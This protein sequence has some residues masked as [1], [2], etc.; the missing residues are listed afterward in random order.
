MKNNPL[1]KFLVIP[2]AIL[3]IFVVVKLFS[4]GSAEQ[5]IRAPETVALSTDEA[6]KLGVDGD[7]PGDTL[8]TIVVESRQ[9]KDQVS[10][11]LKNND[12]LKQQNIELQKR[13][14]NIDLN[15]D[16]KLQNV[17]QTMKQEA[18]QQ[19]QTLLDTLQQQ[20]NTLSSKSGS[21]NESGSDLPIGF[22]VQPG[23]GQGFKGG[24]GADVVWIEP[25][26]ATPVDVN[27]KPIAA[28]SNQTASGFNFPT[29]FGESVDRGQNALR[30]GAQS[31]ANEISPQEAR[32]QVRKV[33]TLPQ[34]STLMGSV[35]MSALIG[36]VPIDGTVNDPYPF[37]VLIGPDN[38]TANGIDLPD[39][40]GAVAS[41]T[42][43]GDWTLSCVRGQIKSL[44]FVFNDG[45]VRTLP[46]PQEETNSSQNSNNQNNGN[47]TTI[48][49]GLGWISDAYGIPCISGDRKSN[50]SQYIGSQVLITAAGAGAASLIKSDG[51]SGSF[52]NPQSG[53][54]GSVGGS[55][56]EAMGKIIGQG[57]N[58]VS[59]WV[60]KLYGQ[61]FA[62]V[63]VQ[64]GAKIAVHL[65]Q[66]LT[67]D[68]EL[69]GRKVNYRS[70]ARHVSTALD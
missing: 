49:G 32:K 23:D 61:A 9:L 51:N 46:Q 54:I 5:Q 13:L 19:S 70:G 22:G 2:F 17:Q 48:Q 24:P 60:N 20:Y 66:Q 63:Y 7:T 1:I 39:V 64:P 69:N 21:G 27:G 38:L 10:N 11:A 12:E 15:V 33:Y 58:D 31:V 67:I 26:D 28:G 43:S 52:I 36:R 8:R 65:D 25:Q 3:A 44:T 4:R 35:A 45:T 55:G 57:V 62:A 41:G 53:T 18:Q 56:S 68:Y 42:A 59:S 50:A 14:Q 29:S 47:Q 37:K 6:K 30:T 34:N 40:A 16:N